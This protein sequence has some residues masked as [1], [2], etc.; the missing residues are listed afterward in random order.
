MLLHEKMVIKNTV[1][2]ALLVPRM[3]GWGVAEGMTM[4]W[5]GTTIPGEV[6]GARGALLCLARTIEPVM[7]R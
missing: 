6:D 4:S 2:V 3:L 7:K 5:R 1:D